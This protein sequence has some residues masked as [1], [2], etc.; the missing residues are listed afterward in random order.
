MFF[1]TFSSVSASGE[2]IT[3]STLY[4]S[5]ASSIPSQTDSQYSLLFDFVTTP[6]VTSSSVFFADGPQPERLKRPETATSIQMYF[7]LTGNL[8]P[9]FCGCSCS[10][11][12]K[13][14]SGAFFSGP[15]SFLN[16]QYGFTCTFYQS[17]L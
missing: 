4:F 11:N 14:D 13:K 2:R 6:M 1:W 9:F 5:A 15:E 17:F 12:W 10:S 3:T 7:F 8:P 16:W